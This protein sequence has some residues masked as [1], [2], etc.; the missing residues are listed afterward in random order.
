MTGIL[1]DV[2]GILG[3]GRVRYPKL[4]HDRFLSRRFQF[5]ADLTSYHSTPRILS[6][7]KNVPRNVCPTYVI[8][9]E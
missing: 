8:L 9:S 5:T 1:C 4:G 7:I 6:Y 2:V 3:D